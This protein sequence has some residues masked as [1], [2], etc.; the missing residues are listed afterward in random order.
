MI[1]KEEVLKKE[2]ALIEMI[3]VCKENLLES[4]KNGDNEAS[5]NNEWLL[6][7]YEQQLIEFMDY[8]DEFGNV[9]MHRLL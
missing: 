8:Y 6:G 3:K 5:Y 9:R 1:T 4:V 7:E 2:K